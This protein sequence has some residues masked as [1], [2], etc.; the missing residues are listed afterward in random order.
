MLLFI[1]LYI[2]LELD[3]RMIYPKCVASI[4]I[5]GHPDG[6]QKIV[7]IDRSRVHLLYWNSTSSLPGT[8]I[9]QIYSIL[10]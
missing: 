8:L 3:V 5:L 2:I 10:L 9:L 6:I 7:A 1:I 4:A